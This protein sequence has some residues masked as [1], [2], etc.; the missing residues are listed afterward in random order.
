MSRKDE[1]LDDHEALL[2]GRMTKAYADI[3]DMVREPNF[4][5]LSRACSSMRKWLKQWMA[6]YKRIQAMPEEPAK[7]PVKPE[8]TKPVA[9]GQPAPVR[10]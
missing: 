7:V 9:N 3:E 4:L 5:R 1:L 10:R 8:P 6:E 2:H